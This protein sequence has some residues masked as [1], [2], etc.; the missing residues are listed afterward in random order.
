MCVHVCSFRDRRAEDLENGFLR[1]N[2][3]F[4]GQ[5][6]HEQPANLV[7]M[8]HNTDMPAEASGVEVAILSPE[9]W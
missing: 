2:F 5:P 1:G 6:C 8:D 3:I 9:L 4:L 7:N